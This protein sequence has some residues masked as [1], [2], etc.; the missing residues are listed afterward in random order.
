MSSPNDIPGRT[1]LRSVRNILLV[2]A[3]FLLVVS[4]SVFLGLY[5]DWLWYREVNYAQV[6]RTVLLA[7]V[8]LGVVTGLVC[9]ALVY[10]NLRAALRHPR[11]ALYAAIQGEGALMVKVILDRYLGPVAFA[12]RAA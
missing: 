4:G 6:F 8:L 5:V 11:E 7:K 10:L 2:L 3:G 9:F 1:S 12:G